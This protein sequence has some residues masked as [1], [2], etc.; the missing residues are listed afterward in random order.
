MNKSFNHG[1]YADLIRQYID[2]KRSLGFKM[3][4]TEER[5]RGFDRMTIDR[6]ETAIGISK[7]LFEQWSTLSHHES[8]HT[9]HIR[10]S[11]LRQFSF[12]LQMMGYDSYITP[13]PKY[14]ST[15]EPHIFTK[16]E[17]AA[18]FQ[19]ADKLFLKR[20]YMYS[21]ICVM[22][23]LLRMLYGTGLRISEALNLK[24][25]YVKLDKE[26]LMLKA[27]KNGQDRVV[28][29]SGSLVEVCK[30]YYIYK[31]QQLIDTGPDT[32]FFTAI[33][34]SKCR[35]KTIYELFRTVL[36][37]AGMSHQGRGKGPRLHDFRYPNKNIIQ[38]FLEKA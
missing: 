7:E 6:Q 26:Y 25:R 35:R 13:L 33:N 12:Y 23:T 31:K 11:M 38:T 1:I 3:E 2:Y 22:P 18:I 14:K 24:H 17:I 30:D 32:Y 10:I 20:K 8:G 5:M 19:A 4:D 34:G 28:P 27:C 21:P 36:Y 15:F 37:K 9:R 29:M 16:A